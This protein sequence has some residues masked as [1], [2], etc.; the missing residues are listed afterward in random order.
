MKLTKNKT[1]TKDRCY[2]RHL[3]RQN[4]VFE[5]SSPNSVKPHAVLLLESSKLSFKNICLRNEINRKIPY[6]VCGSIRDCMKD[7]VYGP[8]NS[9][10]FYTETGTPHNIC[11]SYLS[12]SD[13]TT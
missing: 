13:N 8:L 1:Q 6:N 7:T 12:Y 10:G 5:I 3:T 11:H 2:H 9:A 4:P